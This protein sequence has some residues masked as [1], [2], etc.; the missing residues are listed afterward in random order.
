MGSTDIVPGL[1][2]KNVLTETF[3]AQVFFVK[4][5]SGI[6]GLGAGLRP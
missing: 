3:R 6:G 4:P 2:A 1:G 5:G